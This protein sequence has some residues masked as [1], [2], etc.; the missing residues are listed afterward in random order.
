MAFAGY[1]VFHRPALRLPRNELTRFQRLSD[2]MRRNEI[3]PF[4]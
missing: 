4:E 1:L 3:H 2:E